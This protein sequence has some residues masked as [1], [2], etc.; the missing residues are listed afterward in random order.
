MPL[1]VLKGLDDMEHTN[2]GLK[3]DNASKVN[4]FLGFFSGLALISVIGF[5]IL[6]GVMLSGGN[7]FKLGD[8]AANPTNA[9]PQAADPSA[10]APSVPV[11]AI[12]KSDHVLG[13]LKADVQLI[14]YD[15][16]EC[17]F[18]LRHADTIRKIHQEYGDKVAIA[19]RHFPLT[20]LHPDAQKAAEASE[21]A[22]DQ[23]K[24]W[25]MYDKLFEDQ[26]N[27]TMGVDQFKKDA[28]TI[29]LNTKKFN[30]CLDSDEFAS[31]IQQQQ[32]E[33]VTFGVTGTPGNFLNGQL[34]SGAVP[35]EQFKA[36]IDGILK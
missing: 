29:G 5:F 4:F 20:S 8:K 31:K 11:R 3:K 12:D 9:A 15:D 36:A 27:K 18:C 22:A 16:F 1:S 35:F 14:V 13:D 33:G 28:K 24:F 21:C 2:N 19:F 7:S 23:G 10:A 25:E 6:L 30:D 26:A 32:A 17:P 34:I